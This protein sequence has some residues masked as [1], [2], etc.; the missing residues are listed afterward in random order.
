MADDITVENTTPGRRVLRNTEVK[1]GETKTLTDQ[2]DI[3]AAE[4]F[5]EKGDF[6]VLDG[7][8]NVDAESPDQDES[9]EED[10]RN[11]EELKGIDSE[12]IVRE[13]P[14]LED[15]QQDKLIERYDNAFELVEGLDLE[16][17][18]EF[19][20]IGEEYAKDILESVREQV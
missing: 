19:E 17:L 11:E 14:Y 7:E 4:T 20:G 16:E 6:E 1:P 2:K 8:D 18:D 13:L 9:G 12:S 5:I 3:E 15:S 10:S